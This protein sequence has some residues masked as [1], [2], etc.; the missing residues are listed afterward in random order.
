MKKQPTPIAYMLSI[1]PANHGSGLAL[2]YAMDPD[3]SAWKLIGSI[4]TVKNC[5]QLR[6]IEYLK[7]LTVGNGHDV[8]DQ[9]CY[10]VLETWTTQRG[11]AAVESLAACQKMW[12]QA[13]ERV[14]KKVVTFKVNSQTWQ[15][16]TGVLRAKRLAGNDTKAVTALL[17]ASIVP[18]VRL[19]EDQADALV[20][21][22]WWLHAGGPDGQTERTDRKKAEKKRKRE[23][24]AMKKCKTIQVDEAYYRQL[25]LL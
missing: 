24:A 16:Q 6:A 10:L 25:G 9:G 18:G 5:D 20:M 1:D 15:S 13:A 12:I 17:A 21:G 22:D 11:R 14:F 4:Q 7:D 19:S 3:W 23:K 2:W 8:S